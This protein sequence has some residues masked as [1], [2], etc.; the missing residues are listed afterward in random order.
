MATKSIFKTVEIS[1]EEGAKAF[2]DA[3]ES[4]IEFQKT[5]KEPDVAAKCMSREDMEK[6]FLKKG[7]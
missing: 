5:F 6:I 1:T 3:I 7:K 2:L 4:S